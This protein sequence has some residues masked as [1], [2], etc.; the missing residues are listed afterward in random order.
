MR[1]QNTAVYFAL[2]Y[3][4]TAHHDLDSFTEGSS[5]VP[6]EFTLRGNYPNPFNPATRIVFDLP[7]R[8]VVHVKITD[9][10]GR[11]VK[12]LMAQDLEAGMHKTIAID[13]SDM[14]SGTYLYLYRLIAAYRDKSTCY[15]AA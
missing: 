8:A 13:M 10:L 2:L 1:I 3:I 7:Q 6:T 12:T 4:H 15:T 9:L 11:R 5:D 14:V